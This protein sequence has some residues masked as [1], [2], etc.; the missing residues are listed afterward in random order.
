MTRPIGR[1]PG[2]QP[3]RRE[4]VDAAREIFAARG[5][6]GATIRAIADAADVDPALIHHYFG[7]KEKLFEATLEFP[8]QAPDLLVG[9]LAGPSEGIGERLT[10][11]Y[12]ELW[13]DPVTRSQMVIATRASLSSDAAMDRVRPIVVNMLHQAAAGDIP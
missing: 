10:R 2:G 9:A 7:A 3:T 13:E 5:Y 11:A 4:I 6:R 8:E 1:R 12:L